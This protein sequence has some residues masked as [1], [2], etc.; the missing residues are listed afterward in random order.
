MAKEEE[1]TQ[2]PMVQTGEAPNSSAVDIEG[3]SVGFVGNAIY[4]NGSVLCKRDVQ[5]IISAL[6]AL[7]VMLPEELPT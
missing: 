5:K 1:I 4:L 7:Q 6:Q 3:F 2:V